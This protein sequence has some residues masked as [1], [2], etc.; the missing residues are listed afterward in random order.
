MN[1]V[2]ASGNPVGI[3]AIAARLMGFDPLSIAH[4]T[5]CAENGLGAL[6]GVFAIE[7]DRVEDVAQPFAPASH[8]AVS[9]LELALRR[10]FVESLIFK[11]PLLRIPSWGACR[12]YDLWDWFVGRQVRVAF[13]AHSGYAKQWTD[14]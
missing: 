10:S 14:R 1:A 12:Y 9:W 13:F 7:G 8:N 6:P 11:T 3:D 5:L 2:L 4:L